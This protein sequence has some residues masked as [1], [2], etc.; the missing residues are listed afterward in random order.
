MA[1]RRLACVVLLS[2]CLHAWGIARTTLP[3]QD[4][5]KFLRVARQF[6]S[7]PWGDVVRG[8][9]QH[10]L[11]PALIALAQPALARLVGAGSNSWRLAAQG[12]AA[13][14]SV[15]LLFPLFRLARSLFEERA[16]LLAVLLWALLPFPAEV[17]RDTL[18]DPVALLAIAT[19]LDLG[20]VALRDRSLRA[21]LGC[22]LASGLGYLARPEVAV[23]PL[24]LL[25]ASGLGAAR[26]WL[27]GVRVPAW[28][29]GPCSGAV[30]VF[31]ATVGA[32]AVTKGEVSEKLALRQAAGLTSRHDAPR[33]RGHALPPGLDDRRWDFSPKEESDAP[34]RLRAGEAAIRVVSAWAESLAWV[35]APLAVLGAVRARAGWGRGLVLLY[36]LLFGVLLVRHGMTLG[37]VSGRH[38]LSLAIATLPWTAA[39][40]MTV[41]RRAAAWLGWGERGRRRAAW[42]LVGL[43]VACG[44]IA[45]ARPVH[46]SRWGHRAAGRWLAEHAS[47][48]QAVLDTRGWAAFDWGG[49]SYDPWHI[50][51]AITD[52]RLAFIVVG[53][54]ELSAS[55][56]RAETLRALLDFACEPAA[57]F[58]AR[59]GGSGRDVLV[60]RYTRP[61][62]WRGIVP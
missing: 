52:S 61:A 57:A 51:Q 60:Y 32:Y 54:D 11:Y 8:S 49:P 47:P 34:G 37:Y 56:R 35:L 39:G 59:E 42:T 15:G 48:G 1:R 45:Q 38:V 31:L 12:V 13:L 62:S 50:R 25:A 33:P 4:G 10:P 20:V 7:Q 16:A 27:S 6:H 44:A 2:A 23:L 41:G 29:P 40:I 58:P 30:V 21:G 17:G 3:A 5:L 19:A 28:R 22:G 53:A 26:S 43:A 36:V 46:A 14:C 24:A 55:S 18:S 9:D